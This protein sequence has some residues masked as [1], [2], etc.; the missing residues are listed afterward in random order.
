M[1]YFDRL[2][3]LE[4]QMSKL[5]KRICCIQNEEPVEP[6]AARFGV[7]TEDD[8][9][10]A[11]RLFKTGAFDFA[12][13]KD[14][15]YTNYFAI[16]G[17]GSEFEFWTEDGDNYT[18]YYQDAYGI[19]I[20]LAEGFSEMT[21]SGIPEGNAEFGLGLTSGDQL[22]KMSS[23]LSSFSNGG[24]TYTGTGFTS[25]VLMAIPNITAGRYRVTAMLALNTAISA[26]GFNFQFTYSGSI[27]NVRTYYRSMLQNGTTS[28]EYL[29]SSGF[30]YSA[31]NPPTWNAPNQ[32]GVLMVEGYLQVS[33]TGTLTFQI[34]P[35]TG[36]MVTLS[37]ASYI[38]LDRI[39][40]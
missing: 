34:Q 24:E 10:D 27:T 18:N 35:I 5:E 3:L 39:S 28:D 22:V 2:R 40:N 37:A 1:T 11:H 33:S 12:I 20:D 17:G 23:G 13:G 9:S 25:S 26:T 16:W 7:A 19:Y 31:Y 14:E 4:K 29:E 32:E 38:K 15:N 30:G 21:I 6:A 36:S 8:T